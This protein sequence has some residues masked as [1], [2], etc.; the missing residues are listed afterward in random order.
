MVRLKLSRKAAET[1]SFLPF[2]PRALPKANDFAPLAVKFDDI[3]D[4]VTVQPREAKLKLRESC[5]QLF[6][7]YNH[8]NEGFT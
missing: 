4:V 1:L 5:K 2:S 7:G 6:L 3:D 8:N